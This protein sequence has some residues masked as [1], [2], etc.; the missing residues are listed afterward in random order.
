LPTVGEERRVSLQSTYNKFVK[1]LHEFLSGHGFEY[2]GS[3]LFRKISPAGDILIVE[4]Q[5]SSGSTKSEK[6][7]YINVAFTLAPRWEMDRKRYGLDDTALPKSM[8][9]MWRH[10][11]GHTGYS[12]TDR[13]LITDD[14]SSTTWAD[15]QRRLEES[16]PELLQLLDRQRLRELAERE[17]LVGYAA[18]QIRAWLLADEGPS[19]ELDD[20]LFGQEPA[21]THNSPITRAIVDYANSRAT[22]NNRNA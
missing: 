21:D 2:E 22:A 8:H 10:R 12:G 20:L 15:A 7:F 9:G 18:W 11:I 4:L 1:S 6:A 13:W 14:A 5:T 17:E 3:R 19:A 16:L